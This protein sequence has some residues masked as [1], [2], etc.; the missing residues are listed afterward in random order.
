MPVTPL[1]EVWLGG[2]WVDLVALRKA[3]SIRTTRGRREENDRHDAG[4]LFAVIDNRGREFDPTNTASPYWPH[5]RPMAP[6]RLRLDYLGDTYDRWFGYVDDWPQEWRQPND[7]LVT[8]SATD[9]FKILA[10][11]PLLSFVK[12]EYLADSPVAAYMLDEQPGSE[13]AAELTGSFPAAPVEY[14]K[15]PAG[16]EYAFGDAALPHDDQA[17]ALTLTPHVKI[18]LIDYTDA[19]YVVRLRD[20]AVG[21]LVPPTNGMTV[22]CAFN[23]ASTTDSQAI[24][25]QY[26]RFGQ[27]E[28]VL[29]LSAGGLAWFNG[30][31]SNTP[32]NDGRWHH[33]AG[34]L[35]ADRQTIRTYLDGVEVASF[36]MGAAV[37]WSPVGAVLGG[38]TSPAFDITSQAFDG[39]LA[40]FAIH[41][42]PLAADRIAAHADAVL[43]GFA[44]E[45][46]G[47]RVNRL[48]DY[49]AWPAD[50]RDVD[51][52]SSLVGPQSL[53]GEALP[54]LQQV[55]DTEAGA[56]FMARDGKVRF[57][58]RHAMITEPVHAEAQAVFGDQ[59][60]ELKYASDSL[61]VGYGDEKVR[62]DVSATRVGG[63]TQRAVD[64][65]SV[66]GDGTV[67]GFG[68]RHYE[69]PGELVNVSDAE[70]FDHVHH[71][72][73]LYSQ[74]RPRVPDI[75]VKPHRDPGSLVP[76]LLA[77]DLGHRVEVR[78]TPPGGGARIAL[79]VL[80]ESEAEAFTPGLWES[81]AWSVSPALDQDAALWR[82]SAAT[83]TSAWK[84]DAATSTAAWVY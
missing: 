68:V 34:V 63:V 52:G 65:E 38:L 61:R 35:E 2:A 58:E 78:R 20:G 3:R 37:N 9:G 28:A 12:H 26:D 48:L 50:M 18:D 32:V 54:A 45:R 72:L 19:G 74:P 10:K 22:E 56:L 29:K 75:T 49:A 53:G 25:G 39:H 81:A 57:R 40:A 69:P 66:D 60:G 62:N 15:G 55:E 23:S 82:A 79:E 24:F 11:T 47:E 71:V 83:S 30:V 6:L 41:D 51:A 70:V 59:P 27:W 16:A 1:L 42:H 4:R 13:S 43:T 76:A 80:V 7:A 73:A 5:V 84:A 67:P 31:G 36:V 33:V 14:G 46:S 21:P 8:V 44:G 64:Q 17:T 77:A